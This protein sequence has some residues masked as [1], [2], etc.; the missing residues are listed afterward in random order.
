MLVYRDS[1]LF[2]NFSLFETKYVDF[3]NGFQGGSSF[4]KSCFW[5]SEKSSFQFFFRNLFLFGRLRSLLFE[6]E[7]LDLVVVRL[8]CDWQ[9]TVRS[10][11]ASLNA[12]STNIIENVVAQRARGSRGVKVA[13]HS[14]SSIV[15]FPHSH[16]PTEQCYPSL[17]NC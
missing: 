14:S 2:R 9:P 16:H 6:H 15:F 12:S 7:V 17:L 10:L 13:A 8:L 5:K 1:E 3:C 11:A 4:Q